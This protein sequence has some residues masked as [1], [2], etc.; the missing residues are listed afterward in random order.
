[1]HEKDF[2]MR[3]PGSKNM[4]SSEPFNVVGYCDIT[5]PDQSK[6]VLYNN[7]VTH[8]AWFDEAGCILEMVVGSL[9]F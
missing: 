9:E 3:M 5:D 2:V 6:S 7:P 4:S 1:M 8:N